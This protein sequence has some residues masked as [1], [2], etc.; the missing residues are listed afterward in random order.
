METIVQELELKI[1]SLEVAL[2]KAGEF[3]EVQ[4]Y[5][6]LQQKLAE[7][8]AKKETI[9]KHE[10]YSVVQSTI[11]K[12]DNLKDLPSVKLFLDLLEKQRIS[13]NALETIKQMGM[14]RN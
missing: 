9:S 12:I 5:I 13:K 14:P 8:I 2:Q 6:A 3:S 4:E 1:E 11:K 10:Y 7:Y